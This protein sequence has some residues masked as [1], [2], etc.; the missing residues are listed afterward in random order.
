[1]TSTAYR[2]IGN[3]TLDN[4]TFNVYGYTFS[5]NS[6]KTIASL[7]LPDNTNVRLLGIELLQ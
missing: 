3:G 1:V 2:D 4:R 5:V 7:T 6:S